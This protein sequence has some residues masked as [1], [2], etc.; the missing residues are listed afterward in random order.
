MGET[1]LYHFPILIKV[2]GTAKHSKPW[3]LK[4]DSLKSSLI[5]SVPVFFTVACSQ[6]PQLSFCTMFQARADKVLAGEEFKVLFCS[7]GYLPNSNQNRKFYKC[8]IDK[9]KYREDL[10]LK[11]PVC[12]SC[13]LRSRDF[14]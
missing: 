6:I 5:F 8:L 9:V 4:F 12:I 14:F 2:N 11:K 10:S 3:L 1:T 7:Q 13:Y